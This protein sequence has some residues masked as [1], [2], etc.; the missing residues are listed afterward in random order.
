[1]KKRLFLLYLKLGH[2]LP[3]DVDL[4]GPDVTVLHFSFH[5]KLDD[6]TRLDRVSNQFDL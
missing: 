4:V 6:V 2:S 3:L 5:L 1:M